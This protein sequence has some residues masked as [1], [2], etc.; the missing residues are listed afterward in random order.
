MLVEQ[1]TGE[2]RKRVDFEE[3]E[4]E[5]GRLQIGY[6]RFKTESRICRISQGNTLE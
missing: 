2:R 1:N 3:D 5:R 6:V 4:K